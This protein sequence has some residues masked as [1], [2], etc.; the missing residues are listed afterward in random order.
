MDLLVLT[1]IA[2]AIA[3]LVL[4]PLE[5]YRRMQRTRIFQ[6][7]GGL[8]FEA[9]NF[10]VQI[11]RRQQEVRVRC[12]RGVLL[13][14]GASGGLEPKAGPV[15][16][17]FAAVG[18]SLELRNCV[19]KSA[20]EGESVAT[21]YL[22][23]V[24]R[25]AD[26]TQLTIERVGRTVAANFQYF[27][28][29]VRVW[30]DKLEHRIE[31]ER[32]ARVRSEEEAAQAQRDADL[33][34]TLLGGRPPDTALTDAE[35]EAM[36]AAQIAQWRGAAGF[37]GLHT[38]HFADAKGRV[39]WF[40]DLAADGRITLH[41]DKRTLCTTMLGASVESLYGELE[42]GVRDAH[43]TQRDSELRTFKILKGATAQE[44]RDWKVRLEAMRHSLE[45]EA[46][47]PELS[48]SL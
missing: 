38:A 17:T 21:G 20:I 2:V 32:V 37:E 7:A 34:A 33:M 23:I 25:D 44:R 46:V 24:M 14:P 47:L 41:A 28:L 29:Q 12:A 31:R 4:V 18:F 26:G 13:L 35:R 11:Q 48:P 45:P 15:E 5:L 16:R 10:A 19:K 8:R 30:I 6:V 27:Y 39:V 22:D 1:L 36:A 42:V 9:Y 40:V 43:W 3:A